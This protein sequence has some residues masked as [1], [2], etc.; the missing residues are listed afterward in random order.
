MTNFEDK[1]I[2]G[3]VISQQIKDEVKEEV[4]ALKEQG[5]YPSL[6]VV[7]LG[8]DPA[9]HVYVRNKELGSAYCGIESTVIR[10]SKDI[11]EEELLQI[12]D[13]L[14]KDKNVHGILVQMPIPEHISKEKVILAIN[15]D[16]DVDG[17]HPFNVGQLLYGNSEVLLPCTPSGIMELLDRSGVEIAGKQVVV[18]GRSNIVGKPILHMLLDRNA[19]VTICHSKTVD[20]ASVTKQADI[21]IVAIGRAKMITK[22]HVK[23]GAVVIDVGVNRIDDKLYGDVDFEAVAPIVSKITPVPRGVGPMT[24][25]MLMKNTVKAAKL[26][27]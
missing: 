25:A 27:K 21:L 4:V 19:T 17:F 9:S 11:K 20:L 2:S 8:D 23:E 7:L 12:I 22:E 10:Q 18:V 13:G 3:K 24:I 1:I 26:S 15:P 14:N 6:V 5:I 16:K